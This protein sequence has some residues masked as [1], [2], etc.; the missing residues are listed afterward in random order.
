M[1]GLPTLDQSSNN[2]GKIDNIKRI[3][4]EIENTIRTISCRELIPMRDINLQ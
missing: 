3:K 2:T 1:Q 4:F